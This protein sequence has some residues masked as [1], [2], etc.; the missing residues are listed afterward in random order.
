MKEESDH[1]VGSGSSSVC[2]IKGMILVAPTLRFGCDNSERLAPFLAAFRAII[3]YW[4]K[5]GSD[6]RFRLIIDGRFC[7][8]IQFFEQYDLGEDVYQRTYGKI[9]HQ[10]N[11]TKHELPLKQRDCCYP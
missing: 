7:Q 5:V 9:S 4:F 1:L 3:S 6:G 8:N 11:H 10:E 2:Q